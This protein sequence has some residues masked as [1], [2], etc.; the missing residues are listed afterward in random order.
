MIETKWPELPAT[1]DA[2]QW[3]GFETALHGFA[4]RVTALAHEA[5]AEAAAEAIARKAAKIAEA[6]KAAAEAEAEAAAEAIVRNA[7]KIAEANKAAAETN[8]LQTRQNTLNDLIQLQH[9]TN[10]AIPLH[11]LMTEHPDAHELGVPE[12]QQAILRE[13]FAWCVSFSKAFSEG[14]YALSQWFNQRGFLHRGPPKP[15]QHK[16]GAASE[17]DASQHAP[18]NAASVDSKQSAQ[19]LVMNLG[20]CFQQMSDGDDA[21]LA[22]FDVEKRQVQ[23]FP[24][25]S[26]EQVIVLGK[27]E[28][29]NDTE[30]CVALLAKVPTQGTMSFLR[31]F[32]QEGRV[33][34]TQSAPDPTG[35]SALAELPSPRQTLH[36]V[37]LP[38]VQ[39]TVKGWRKMS[40]SIPVEYEEF[41]F[42]APRVHLLLN[43]ATLC[44]KAHPGVQLDGV[45]G[46]GKTTLLR[47]L[48]GILTTGAQTDAWYLPQASDLQLT[49]MRG[50]FLRS[51]SGLLAQGN[52]YEPHGPGDTETQTELQVL[53]DNFSLETNLWKHHKSTAVAFKQN[54]QPAQA[55]QQEVIPSIKLTIHDEVNQVLADLENNKA[56]PFLEWQE[57]YPEG[58]LRILAS[59]PDGY[60]E[61]VKAP[62]NP[63]FFEL[64]P[65]PARH[66]AAILHVAGD[67]L[68]P[69]LQSAE[70][71]SLKLLLKACTVLGSNMR[72]LSLLLFAVD[73]HIQKQRTSLRHEEGLPSAQDWREQQFLLVFEAVRRHVVSKLADRM[74]KQTSTPPT[75]GYRT[76]LHLPELLGGSQSKAAMLSRFMKVNASLLVRVDPTEREETKFVPVSS[77]MYQVQEK[78]FMLA[79]ER[80]QG[81]DKD[82]VLLEALVKL[83][84][85]DGIKFEDQLAARLFLR[86]VSQSAL[87]LQE[88]PQILKLYLSGDSSCRAPAV[89]F[90]QHLTGSV[91]DGI[92]W[93]TDAEEVGAA[94]PPILIR[95]ESTTV[96]HSRVY[97]AL[98]NAQEN[99]N[100]IIQTA[101]RAPYCDFVVFRRERTQTKVLFA[102]GTV[103]TLYEHSKKKSTLQIP[104][105]DATTTSI[106][107]PT[108]GQRELHES[109]ELSDAAPMQGVQHNAS[110]LQPASS[111]ARKGMAGAGE[112][113]AT[114]ASQRIA[115]MARTKR[116]Q[117]ALK[118]GPEHEVFH[119][120]TEAE[121]AATTANALS[122]R[123]V[124]QDSQRATPVRPALR[125]LLHLLC[126]PMYTVNFNGSV[127]TFDSPD[128]NTEALSVGNAWLQVLGAPVRFNAVFDDEAKKYKVTLEPSSTHSPLPWHI[129]VAY[130]SGEALKNQRHTGL[131]QLDCDFAFTVY[132]ELLAGDFSKIVSRATSPAAG[133]GAGSAASD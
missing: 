47:A 57:D 36:G 75:E 69:Q 37:M 24:L 42:T 72:E 117:W 116:E 43:C 115:E 73:D 25:E 103:G 80:S 87:L 15:A 67:R 18:P 38:E 53:L 50:C 60:R 129:G 30:E 62:Y 86:K 120:P 106:S 98:Q 110:N 74:L 125:D 114:R 51:S 96:I 46:S 55:V 65:P 100:I 8:R 78:A 64:R 2:L 84:F 34:D 107:E 40:S 93:H 49:Q 97:T 91:L 17:A 112:Q 22:D 132:A 105:G 70:P 23:G 90:G 5:E 29:G 48:V 131:E 121:R 26:L 94:L 10:H 79:L 83:D 126:T 104:A 14:G 88:L 89:T 119:P 101:H 28:D 82:A 27:D 127:W 56:A 111:S 99:R 19:K 44:A 58:C 68:V 20:E 6:N 130:I 12:E 21:A 71:W 133:A 59:S 39:T 128:S 102:E 109:Q 35:K 54:Q 61:T 113:R 13:Y 33:A 108:S 95:L 41:L 92:L 123:S 66:M 52:G 122:S 63:L 81:R 124:E 1:I 4:K 16:A 118:H 45:H 77:I 9:R 76:V 11:L 85:N 3:W 7:A 31:T 32:R